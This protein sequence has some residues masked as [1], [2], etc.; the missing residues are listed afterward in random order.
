MSPG[1]RSKRTDGQTTGSILPI[2]IALVPRDGVPQE[3]A[4]A[5]VERVMRTRHGLR[6][7]QLIALVHEGH[8]ASWTVQQTAL[9]AEVT[10]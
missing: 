2:Q 8:A 1:R 10:A 5:D 6:L 9:D 4:I 3:D 7:D